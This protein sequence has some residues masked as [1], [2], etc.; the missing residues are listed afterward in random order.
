MHR[1]IRRALYAMWPDDVFNDVMGRLHGWGLDRN[2]IETYLAQ[3]QGEIVPYQPP[4][5][6]DAETI[7]GYDKEWTGEVL[8]KARTD[9][10]LLGVRKNL[11]QT[12]ADCEWYKRTSRSIATAFKKQ[13]SKRKIKAQL[14]KLLG[15]EWTDDIDRTLKLPLK[16]ARLALARSFFKR[17][18]GGERDGKWEPHEKWDNAPSLYEFARKGTLAHDLDRSK[19][20]FEFVEAVHSVCGKRPFELL[21]IVLNHYMPRDFPHLN[22]RWVERHWR[23]YRTL[24]GRDGRKLSELEAKLSFT[25][26]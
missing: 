4:E 3:V 5:D 2:R 24:A 10:V 16:D 9:R 22:L 23:R 13:Y 15:S 8:G 12:A 25:P 18:A 20:V 6:A 7:G 11:K 26:L 21:S 14:L 17:Y 19:F 1:V